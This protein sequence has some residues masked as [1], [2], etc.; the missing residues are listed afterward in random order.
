MKFNPQNIFLTLVG[1]VCVLVLGLAFFAAGYQSGRVVG[2]SEVK[3]AVADYLPPSTQTATSL[4]GT[5][6]SVGE[7]RMIV[8]VG[9]VSLNP[10]DPKGPAQR[11]VLVDSSTQMEEIASKTSAQLSKERQEYQQAV[12]GGKAAN[13]P[14]PYTT[15]KLTVKDFSEGDRV[16]VSANSDIYFAES[17]TATEIQRLK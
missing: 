15:K 13:P 11:T 5:V 9:S 17:F 12:D 14:A 4:D 7:G 1:I 8:R 6:V 10:L 3:Q 2:S 16:R